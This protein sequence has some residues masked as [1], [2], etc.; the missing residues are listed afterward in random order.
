[1]RAT[2]NAP[3]I[4]N[5]NYQRFC[6]S[7]IIIPRKWWA[8][9]LAE[10]AHLSTIKIAVYLL[11][12]KLYN[13]RIIATF[14]AVVGCVVERNCL[15]SD[16]RFNHLIFQPIWNYFLLSDL[17][18]AEIKS[19][20]IQTLLRTETIATNFLI[21]F[22]FQ[23]DQSDFNILS[24][25]NYGLKAQSDSPRWWKVHTACPKHHLSL[26]GCDHTHCFV[27][28][29]SIRVIAE[30]M[31]RRKCI[32]KNTRCHCDLIIDIMTMFIYQ[33]N[34]SSSMPI[35]AIFETRNYRPPNVSLWSDSLE[36][37]TLI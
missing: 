14:A 21:D 6:S 13:Q 16:Y 11:R 30:N 8:T 10:I 33:F 5:R 22:K 3:E 24:R 34:P 2:S 32:R 35:S 27:T 37:T 31:A 18:K 20:A 36:A 12:N 9:W 26:F 17:V 1:M 4:D 7:L 23:Q 19:A 15:I 29:R 25:L 28:T